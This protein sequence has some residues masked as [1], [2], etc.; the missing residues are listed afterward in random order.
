MQILVVDKLAP[1][2]VRELSAFGTVT[3]DTAAK[4]AALT[5][6]IADRNPEVLIVRSTKVTAA[7][8]EAGRAL[9]LVIRAGAGVN[10]IDLAAASARG[11]YVANCPGK[12]AIAV[13]ELAIG[14]L[15]NL[16]RRIA[17][18]VAALRE[19]R[20]DKKQFGAARGLFGRTLAVLGVGQI[21]QETITRARAFGMKIVAWSRSLTP[22]AAA[23]LGVERAESP[24]AAVA[25]A[26]AVSVHLALSPETRGFVGAAVFAAMKPGAFFIN[27]ARAEV[28][29]EEALLRAVTDKQLRVGLDVFAKEPTTATGTFADPLVDSP[30]VYGTHHIGAST[31]QSEEAVGAAVVEIVAAYH[32]GSA[33]P[34]C[35]NL[36]T[37]TPAT[38]QLVIR[39]A[40]K[41]GVLAGV[42]AILREA[43]INVETMQNI[44]FSG[45]HA[46]C[47]RISTVG[48]LADDTLARLAGSSHVFAVSQVK[49]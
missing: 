33:I 4:D 10:T 38:H 26:D 22:A 46:A 3:V 35:V 42:L 31:D 27:T 9:A 13:A 6:A 41:V 18:N 48:E 8:I 19:H 34:N 49:L 39:H 15:I 2:V 5:R 20:W 28:V 32:A 36:A 29:D 14:H 17:D 40:D 45:G 11:V 44:I 25:N 24:E 47:A 37:R 1:A 7:D 30:A 43:D 21:G 16:D 12:N 23:A